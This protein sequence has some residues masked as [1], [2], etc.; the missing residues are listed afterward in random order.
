VIQVP[1]TVAMLR[2]PKLLTHPAH[3]FYLLLSIFLK[4]LYY[5]TGCYRTCPR[6]TTWY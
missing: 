1:D 5:S 3:I 4:Y 2:V 6:L